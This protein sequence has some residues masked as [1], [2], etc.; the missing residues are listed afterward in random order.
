MIVA[1]VNMLSAGTIYLFSLYGP[2]LAEMLEFSAS[3]TAFIAT[4]GNYGIYLSG[5]FWG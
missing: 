3:Q 4:C 1:S 2:Q 5:P